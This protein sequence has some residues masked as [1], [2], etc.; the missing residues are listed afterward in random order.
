MPLRPD[1]VLKSDNP[2]HVVLVEAKLTEGDSTYERD[3]IRDL[4]A[5]LADLDHASHPGLLAKGLVVAWNASAR[6]ESNPTGR[7]RVAAQGDI[8]GPLADLLS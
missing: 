4:M 7:I 8:S 5:Y 3:G 6:L 1:F 2:H